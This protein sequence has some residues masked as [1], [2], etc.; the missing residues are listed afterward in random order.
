MDNLDGSSSSEQTSSSSDSENENPVHG[1]SKVEETKQKSRQLQYYHRKTGGKMKRKYTL[2]RDQ[3]NPSRQ[4]K[5]YH[6]VVREA[7]ST[8]P[9]SM[10]TAGSAERISETNINEDMQIGTTVEI[11]NEEK[12]ISPYEFE[13]EAAFNTNT[14]SSSA[15]ESGKSFSDS[16]DSVSGTESEEW[17]NEPE[18]IVPERENETATTLPDEEKPLFQGS[19]I[20]KILS[21]VL[22]V[23]FVLK[24]NLSKAAWADLLR[25]LTALLGDRCRQTFQSVYKMKVI[26]KEYF[27]S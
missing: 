16:D 11:Q 18:D 15:E 20:S 13:D 3:E 2:F 6:S 17:D 8:L 26:M 4:L 7:C 23:S 22:I 5:R 27:G 21:C 1:E 9:A 25:L 14:T 12:E 19:T 24:H 10:N